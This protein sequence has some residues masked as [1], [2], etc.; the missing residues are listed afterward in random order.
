[1]GTTRLDY[2]Y[3]G[4]VRSYLL[5][6]VSAFH[7]FCYQSLTRDGEPVLRQIPVRWGNQSRMVAHILRN[8][9]ENIINSAPF[10]TVYISSMSHAPERRQDPLFVDH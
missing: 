9:S 4:Q 2:F 10:I 8:N 5:Q 6:V 1:M 3:D 7:G